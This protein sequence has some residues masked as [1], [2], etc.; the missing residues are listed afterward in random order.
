MKK[1]SIFLMSAIMLFSFISCNSDSDESN[2]IPIIPVV[3]KIEYETTGSDGNS[4]TLSAM[5]SYPSQGMIYSAILYCHGTILSQE[6]APSNDKSFA[7]AI[8]MTFTNSLIVSPDYEGYGSDAENPHPY[9]NVEVSGKQSVDALLAAFEYINKK[10]SKSAG[11]KTYLVGYSQGAQVALAC[12]KYIENE[13]PESIATKINIAENYCGAGPYSLKTTMAEFLADKEA[14]IK[15]PSILVYSIMGMC[16]SYPEIFENNG[17]YPI[18]YF[19][20]D[21][22][23][24]H[25]DI[26][27]SINTGKNFLADID[28]LIQTA[29]APETGIV[30]FNNL[31]SSDFDTSDS[32]LLYTSLIEAFEK[33]DLT[34][35]WVPQHPLHLYHATNDDLVT[36]KNTEKAYEDFISAGCLE[37]NLP[38]PYYETVSNVKEGTNVH[39]TFAQKTFLTSVIL[40]ILY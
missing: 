23:N 27:A 5:I 29:V 9:L 7:Q 3:E 32:N 17:I 4:R 36:V 6:E 11:L 24:F 8:G 12:Q 16:L 35:G 26:I 14:E 22:V 34:S 19:S 2:S 15:S 10:A 30:N 1:L 21:F 33:N 37:T 25:A 31:F 20:D 18:N 39:T 28:F 38:E 13:L 40:S